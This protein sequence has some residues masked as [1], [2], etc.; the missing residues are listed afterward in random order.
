[1]AYAS[2][3]ISLESSLHLSEFLQSSTIGTNEDLL[4]DISVSLERTATLLYQEIITQAGLGWPDNYHYNTTVQLPLPTVFNSFTILQ[5]SV[6]NNQDL[7]NI[8]QASLTV[9]ANTISQDITA[10]EG[11]YIYCQI[12][13]DSLHF[14]AVLNNLPE[15]S[16][17]SVFAIYWRTIQNNIGDLTTD[18][19]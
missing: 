3:A 6:Y 15:F 12:Q 2:V 11:A 8:L 19:H 10:D 4:Q 7:M 18:L 5:R 14:T 9:T 16:Y 17:D 1:M 13:C